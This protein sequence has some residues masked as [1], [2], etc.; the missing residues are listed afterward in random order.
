V[1]GRRS[2]CGGGRIAPGRRSRRTEEARALGSR[3]GGQ[4]AIADLEGTP[5][6]EINDAPAKELEGA[7]TME[8]EGTPARELEVA[9]STATPGG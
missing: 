5:R 3:G 7:P 8:L 9:T 2:R 6:R 1:P 4:A